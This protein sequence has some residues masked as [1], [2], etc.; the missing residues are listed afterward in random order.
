MQPGS[1]SDRAI[2]YCEMNGIECV[3]DACIMIDRK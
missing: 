2:A 1:E 3:H